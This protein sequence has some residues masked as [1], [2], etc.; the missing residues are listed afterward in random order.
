[1]RVRRSILGLAAAVLTA[2]AVGEASA[3]SGPVN[4]SSHDAAFFSEL[5]KDRVWLFERPN[6]AQAADRGLVWGIHHGDDGTARACIHLDGAWQAR[7]D[8]WRVVPSPRFRALYN[9]HDAGTE[10][11]PGHVKGH[12]PVFYDPDT[13]RLHSESVGAAGSLSEWFVLSLGWV[14]ESWPQALRDACPDLDL[15]VGVPINAKQTSALMEEA[16]A[17]DPGAVLR[18]VQ[19]SSPVP[20]SHL[21]APGATGLAMAAGAPTVTAAELMRFLAANG[22]HVLESPAGARM[23]LV[24]GAERDELWRLDADGH[25][26]DTAVLLSAADGASI[27]AQW[28]R[29]PRRM[30]YRL[31]DPFPLQPTG[32][33]Y[34]AMSLTD[35][36]VSAGRPVALPLGDRDDIALRFHEGGA[37]TAEGIHGG[38]ISGRWRWSRGQLQVSLDGVGETFAWPW[39]DLERHPGA[40]PDVTGGTAEAE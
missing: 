14:Q 29:L 26:A 10:P 37:V 12:V 33:R 7:E 20:G 18:E 6:S 5:L 3:Q 27:V 15:P 17:Q 28:E 1:M 11:D 25:V 21:H 36:L 13:G 19:G 2:A 8:R 9:Y 39:R 30:E 38:T 40:L 4:Y 16:V 24:L 35:R 22:G 23:V 34:G 32:E 31:G